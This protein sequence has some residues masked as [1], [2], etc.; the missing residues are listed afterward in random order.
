M[1]YALYPTPHLREQ[2]MIRNDY[3]MRLVEQFTQALAISTGFKQAKDY[4]KALSVIQNTLQQIFGVDPKF[5]DTIHEEDLLILLRSG[6][7]VDPDRAVMIAALEKSAGEIYE[8]QGQEEKAYYAYL[9]SL[10]LYLEVLLSDG[11]TVLKEYIPELDTLLDKFTDFDLSTSTKFRLW[12]YYEKTGKYASAE[13]AL[14]ELLGDEESGPEIVREGVDFYRRLLAKSDP[15][16]MAGRL[17]REE[18]E[19]GLAKL[20]QQVEKNWEE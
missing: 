14:Y 4:P 17:P 20:E 7:T 8:A 15:E 1:R 6:N 11:D 13:D 19:E 5:I 18:V 16:L 12:R 2:P 3:Y 10:A 9:K